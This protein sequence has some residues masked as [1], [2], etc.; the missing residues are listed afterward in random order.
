MF[1]LAVIWAVLILKKKAKLLI[2]FLPPV[3]IVGMLMLSCPSQDPR[4][5]LPMMETGMMGIIAAKF[6]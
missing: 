3:L 2:A 4:F 6:A 1:I 5:V